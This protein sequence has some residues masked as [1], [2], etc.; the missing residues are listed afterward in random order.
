MKYKNLKYDVYCSRVDQNL[1]LSEM[2]KE[3]EYQLESANQDKTEQKEIENINVENTIIKSTQH[4]NISVTDKALDNSEINMANKVSSLIEGSD[5]DFDTLNRKIS[6]DTII[7]RTKLDEALSTFNDGNELTTKFNE[8]NHMIAN[9]V[10]LT[11]KN[12]GTATNTEHSVDNDL[13]DLNTELPKKFVFLKSVGRH[14]ALVSK[15]LYII[16]SLNNFLY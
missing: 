5:Y 16:L 10:D 7:D 4:Q 1:N 12:D 8:N 3:M 6:A 11:V 9:T 15:F 2:R 13:N 14:F